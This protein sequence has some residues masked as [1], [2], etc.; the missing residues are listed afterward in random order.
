MVAI[1]PSRP[2]EGYRV[3]A[4][5]R[6]AVDATHDF[7]SPEDRADIHAEVAAFLPE[8]PVLVATDQWDRP[9]GFMLLDGTQMEALFIDPPW[10]GRGVGRALVEH[11]LALHPALTTDVNEQN[12]QAVGFYE[13]MGFVRTGRSEVDG[14][15][16]PYPLIHMRYSAAARSAKPR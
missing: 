6:A 10:R 15:G 14:Q 5:W 12:G 2:E 11:G 8:V 3:L 1:R 4:I 7:L 9:I 16:C 13:R